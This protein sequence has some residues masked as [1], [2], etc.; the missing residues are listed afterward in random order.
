MVRGGGN[1]CPK[2]VL[3]QPAP[4]R[5]STGC[6][7]DHGDLATA[8]LNMNRLPSPMLRQRMP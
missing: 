3:A 5:F 1:H 2:A 7:N 6:G 8:K 4:G